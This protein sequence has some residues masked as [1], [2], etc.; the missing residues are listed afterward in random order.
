MLKKQY[1]NK[2]ILKGLIAIKI[3]EV[4]LIFNKMAIYTRKSAILT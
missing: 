4:L 2:F 3:K 1:I